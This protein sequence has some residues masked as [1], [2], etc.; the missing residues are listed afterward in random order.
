MDKPHGVEKLF[1]P[2]KP[3]RKRNLFLLPCKVLP[4]RCLAR[5]LQDDGIFQDAKISNDA[6]VVVTKALIDDLLPF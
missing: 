1:N 3:E 5:K 2:T 4:N 6:A